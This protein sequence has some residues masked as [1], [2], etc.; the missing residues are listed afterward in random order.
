MYACDGYRVPLR[1]RA[2][3]ER[4]CCCWSAVRRNW[5]VKVSQ[6]TRETGSG[7]RKPLRFQLGAVAYGLGVDARSDAGV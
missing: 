6:T 4:L 2:D 1:E 7:A 5:S 3:A